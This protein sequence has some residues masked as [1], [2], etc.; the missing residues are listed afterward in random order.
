M[1]TFLLACL[2]ANACLRAALFET[3]LPRKQAGAAM[4]VDDP[5]MSRYFTDKAEIPLSRAAL[6]PEPARTRFGEAVAESFGGAVIR[7]EWIAAVL[8]VVDRYTARENGRE[9]A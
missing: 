2:L 9:V 8:R 3:Q 1:I 4:G 7:H 6:L 5:T